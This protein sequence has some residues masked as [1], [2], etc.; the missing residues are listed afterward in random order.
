MDEEGQ[1]FL[2]IMTCCSNS[3]LF[4]PCEQTTQKRKK[5]KRVLVAGIKVCKRPKRKAPS[6]VLTTLCMENSKELAVWP[7]TGIKH[8]MSIMA[9]VFLSCLC[10]AVF[11]HFALSRMKHEFLKWRAWKREGEEWI[12]FRNSSPRL[13]SRFPGLNF[14]DLATRG[15]REGI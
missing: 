8:S 6:S 5:R 7:C 9:F 13:S 12:E 14:A 11:P 10:F 2:T 1:T 4:P 3:L 15:A